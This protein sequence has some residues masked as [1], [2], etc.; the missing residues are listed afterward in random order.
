[1]SQER[2]TLQDL[3]DEGIQ[4]PYFVLLTGQ[5][6]ELDVSTYEPYA[7]TH[8]FSV[9]SGFSQNCIKYKDIVFNPNDSNTYIGCISYELKNDF[10]SFLTSRN[11]ESDFEFPQSFF[12]QPERLFKSKFPISLGMQEQY[13][14][15]SSGKIQFELQT[16]KPD[17]V[18]N[19]NKV[20]NWI[21]EGTVYELNYCIELKAESSGFNPI[22]A[23]LKMIKEA[24]NPFSAFVKHQDLYCLCLSMERFLCKKGNQLT[25][26]PIKGT[27][28]RGNNISEDLELAQQ[29]QS[30]PKERAENIMITDLVRND[31]AK[32]SQV[33]TVKVPDL[34]GVYPFPSVHQ[35]ISTVESK[36]KEDIKFDQILKN[37]FPMG[38]MT[39]APKIKAMELIDQIE[40]F[41]RGLYSGSIGYIDSRGDFDLNVVIRSVFYNEKSGK[42][43]I[44]VGSAITIDSVPELEWAECL[45]KINGLIQLIGAEI[46]G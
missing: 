11:L 13:L 43:S 21:K 27:I 46:K 26:Q 14:F 42:L 2:P 18:E 45:S 28:N 40:S 31:L 22:Q 7:Q 12:I 33:G 8:Q 5:R 37:T 39:G 20:I 38:S 36:T 30:N 32:C 16:H 35:M 6:G 19:V 29:L 3:L 4:H 24:G 44:R 23:F 9:L 10:E 25:S 17:Y 15:E 34:C 41:N 1:L